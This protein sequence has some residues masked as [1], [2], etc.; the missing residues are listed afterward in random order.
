MKLLV[1]NLVHV[2][3]NNAVRRLG[4]IAIAIF[5][6]HFAHAQIMNVSVTPSADSFVTEQSPTLNYGSAGALNVSGVNATNGSGQTNGVFASL[7]RFPLAD[8]LAAFNAS[9]GSN[10]WTLT[11]ATL[12]VNENAI[13]DNAIF[14]RGTGT[15]EID[16]ISSDAWAEGTGIPR[17]PTTDGVAWQDLAGILTTAPA[18]SLGQFVS[19][20]MNGVL[21]F[22]L[23][24]APLLI[25][26][27]TVG[28]D[29]NLYLSPVSATIGFTFNSRNF[30][31]T[32]LQPL[33]TLAATKQSQ[34]P[35]LSISITPSNQ[36][37]LRFLATSNQ[38]YQVQTSDVLATN[39]WITIFTYSPAPTNGAVLVTDSAT[40]R[41]RFYR[42]AVGP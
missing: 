22:N 21:N 32:N 4:S 42:L 2:G 10:S 35:T 18:V 33:L 36:I 11:S 13:P 5:F 31:N 41:Q 8:A 7:I 3:T 39:Q 38:T 28:T 12:Q 9:L 25:S 14:S 37:A 1:A 29:L 19:S 15:F 16:V 40:N 26:N 20:G 30:G 23:D 27:L 34:L 17:S 6:A 24:P